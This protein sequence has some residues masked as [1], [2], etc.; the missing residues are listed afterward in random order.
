MLSI[1]FLINNTVRDLKIPSAITGY[2]D[3]MNAWC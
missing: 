1:V 3:R 2:S